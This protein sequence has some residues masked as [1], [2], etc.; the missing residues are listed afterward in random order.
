MIV[1]PQPI[2]YGSIPYLEEDEQIL[3]A[4]VYLFE[5]IDGGNCQLRQEGGVLRT[6]KRSGDWQNVGHH[7]WLPSFTTWAQRF[8][9]TAQQ[10]WGAIITELLPDDL[11]LFGEWT[12]T[13]PELGEEVAFHTIQYDPQHM[14][15][16]FL[17]D[18]YST[19][20]ER[21]LPYEEAVARATIDGL[22]PMNTV[23][24]LHRGKVSRRQLDDFLPGSDYFAGNKEGIVIKDYEHQRFAKY[25][26]PEYRELARERKGIDAYLTPRRA[27]KVMQ[28]ILAEGAPLNRRTFSEGLHAD[29]RKEAPPGLALNHSYIDH[30]ISKNFNDI[31]TRIL[32]RKRDRK[33]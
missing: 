13:N 14:N 26:Q 22:L 19:T 6:A 25:L 18:V 9:A 31:S 1:T 4:P 17:I 32:G 20:E 33:R 23:R 30:W 15:Q 29:L 27:E 28:S 24:I 16:F 7:V 10:E 5:K 8:Y 21:Y 12:A 2:K 11:V 3:D